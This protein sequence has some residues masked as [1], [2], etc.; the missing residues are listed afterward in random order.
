[1]ALLVKF[2]RLKDGREIMAWAHGRK[3]Y[4]VG[5][6]RG[7]RLERRFQGC[8]WPRLWARVVAAVKIDPIPGA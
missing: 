1:M 8:D 3:Q 2:I 6:W 7:A 4:R 5:V